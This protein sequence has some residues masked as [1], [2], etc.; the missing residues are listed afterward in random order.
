MRIVKFSIFI[1][2]MHAFIFAD[3]QWPNNMWDVMEIVD[4]GDGGGIFGPLN[5]SRDVSADADRGY[6]YSNPKNEFFVHN[7]LSRLSNIYDLDDDIKSGK[8][9]IENIIELAKKTPS[10][11]DDFL[12]NYKVHLTIKPEYRI[13]ALHVLK[14]DIKE[15]PELYEKIL[16]KIRIAPDSAMTT[17]VIPFVVFYSLNYN[18][19][20]Q[21]LTRMEKLFGDT[22]GLASAPLKNNCGGP[23]VW[24]AGGD[25]DI[26]PG[27]KD[28]VPS[29]RD[30]YVNKGTHEKPNFAYIKGQEPLKN[31]FGLCAH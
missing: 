10:V 4:D 13:Q 3:N 15:N 25:G 30:L 23:V 14:D 18:D 20:Q 1:L 2:S 8:L 7:V 22:V 26:K 27:G 12:H 28:Y 5:N 21:L 6:Y 24:W 19:I 9:T 11:Y 29:L 17:R 31:K 16:F